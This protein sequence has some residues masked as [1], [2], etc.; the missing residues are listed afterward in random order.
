V[1]L[2]AILNEDDGWCG[3]RQNAREKGNVGGG[4]EATVLPLIK[5]ATIRP[6]AR[7]DFSLSVLNRL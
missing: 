5:E 3:L 6:K 2:R 7:I 4:V 1:I